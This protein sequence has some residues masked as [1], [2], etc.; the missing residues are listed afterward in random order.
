MFTVL[1]RLLF[2][3]FAVATPEFMIVKDPLPIISIAMPLP[4]EIVAPY[5]NIVPKLLK[6]TA[7][8]MPLVLRA[9]M[10]N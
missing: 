5:T 3:M 6:D 9:D 8:K 1:D 4:E 7:A 2:D 10:F